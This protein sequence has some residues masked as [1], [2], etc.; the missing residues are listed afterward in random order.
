[1]PSLKGKASGSKTLHHNEEHDKPVKVKPMK[2]DKNFDLDADDARVRDEAAQRAD[3]EEKKK[4]GKKLEKHDN[5]TVEV[6]PLKKKDIKKKHPNGVLD[7]E[8][9]D[10][11]DTAP[12]K[13]KLPTRSKPSKNAE[14]EE[15]K[16]DDGTLAGHGEPDKKRKAAKKPKK[17][18]TV[19]NPDD[20]KDQED[21]EDDDYWDGKK[22]KGNSDKQ[23]PKKKLVVANPDEDDEEEQQ[24]EGEEEQDDDETAVG[25]DKTR[26]KGVQKVR[27]PPLL[28][29]WIA[30]L[31][32]R[33]SRRRSSTLRI[34]IRIRIRRTRTRTRTRMKRRSLRMRKMVSPSNGGDINYHRQ[35]VQNSSDSRTEE[36]DGEDE[37]EDGEEEDGEEE[38]EEEGD[39]EEGEEEDGDEDGKL[40]PTNAK[41]VRCQDQNKC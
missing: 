20:E 16:D 38:D 1:M 30:D 28:S 32:A 7:G 8:L 24:N 19:A 6:K 15:D 5:D 14:D 2:K 22:S 39:E 10:N 26:K 12:S 34:R 40:T 35:R 18:L 29:I 11:D 21:G 9:S 17:K 23:K 37:E 36:E 3:R 31:R 27:I 33:R 41:E 4:A 13:K 25:H